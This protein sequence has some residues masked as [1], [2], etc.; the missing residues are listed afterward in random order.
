ME[1]T[2][3]QIAQ[4]Q[5]ALVLAGISNRPFEDT[6][7]NIVGFSSDGVHDVVVTIAPSRWKF[8]P[9]NADV[10]TIQDAFREFLTLEPDGDQLPDGVEPK[11]IHT[12]IKSILTRTPKSNRTI[13]RELRLSFR[14]GHFKQALAD[15]VKW[16]WAK[17]DDR[18]YSLGDRR[19]ARDA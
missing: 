7:R 10:M 8:S 15:V 13:A 17:N 2:L 4:Q 16:G 5:S 14:S 18:G 3:A 12:R 9:K 19:K 1:P 6:D 11:R